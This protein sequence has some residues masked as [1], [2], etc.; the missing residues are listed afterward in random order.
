MT[1]TGNSNE[2]SHEVS[3]RH[4]QAYFKYM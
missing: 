2:H 4:W 1:R 3:V